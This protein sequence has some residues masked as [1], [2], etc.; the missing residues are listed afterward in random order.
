MAGG[1]TTV[2]HPHQT[3]VSCCALRSLTNAKAFTFHNSTGHC[4]LLTAG[5]IDPH[6]SAGTA[7]A[8]SGCAGHCPSTP[9]QPPPPPP[10]ATAIP[11]PMP[12]GFPANT[13][14]PAAKPVMPATPTFPKPPKPNIVLFFGDDVG[15]GD[16]GA[17]GNPT[18]GTP[19]LD[20]MAMDGAKLVQYYSAASICS[21][22][23]GGPSGRIPCI[24]RRDL[25]L[26][27]G[28]CKQASYLSF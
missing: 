7:D 20:Q 8:T 2:N 5:P 16:L 21:P 9:P 12:P 22:S 1:G 3:L 6:V 19:H 24:S 27:L 15:Y 10:G 23:R 14:F 11:G 28:L 13:T 4:E 18:S 26:R 25:G 17:F